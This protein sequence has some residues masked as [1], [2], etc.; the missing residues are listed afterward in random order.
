MLATHPVLIRYRHRDEEEMK[1]EK[2]KVEHADDENQKK[3]TN[4]MD[5][6]RNIVT[7]NDT[8]NSF[9]DAQSISRIVVYE[10]EVSVVHHSTLYVTEPPIMNASSDIEIANEGG[11][12]TVGKDDMSITAVDKTVIVDDVINPP[13]QQ[14]DTTQHRKDRIMLA[15]NTIV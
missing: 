15:R 10:T 13:S 12:T 2:K 1:K 14:T 7:T 6:V 5:A 9:Y 4:E 11:K 3:S 8:G